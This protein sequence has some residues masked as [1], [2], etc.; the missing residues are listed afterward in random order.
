[1]AY[2]KLKK[3]FIFFRS[4]KFGIAL[5]F[6]I[7]AVSMIGTVIPQGMDEGLYLSNYSPLAAKLILL[8]GFNSIYNSIVFGALFVMLVINLSLC[9]IFRFNRTITKIKTVPKTETLS[10]EETSNIIPN[11]SINC[12]ID[13]SF[14]KYGFNKYFQDDKTDTYFS[15]KNKVGYFGSWFLHF[16]ILIVIVFYTYG[17]I[18]YFSE[19]VYGVPGTVQ[20]IEGTEYMVKISDFNIEYG[21]DGAIQQYTSDIELTDESG[22]SLIDSHVAV[23][24]PMRYKGYSF[25][26]TGYGWTA[27]CN[28]FKSGASLAEEIIYEQTTLNLPNENITIYFNK[29]YPDFAASSGGFSSL[30]DQLTNPVILY[31]VFYRGNVVKM[32]I[33]SVDE[34]IKWNEYEFVFNS[35]IRYTYLEVNKMNG[36]LGALIGA[37]LIVI[38]LILA[39]YYKPSRMMICIKEGKLYVFKDPTIKKVYSKDLG[40]EKDIYA[41]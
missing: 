17:N 11:D 14:R 22:K 12:L 4:M 30:T 39:F 32:D 2:K 5:L 33:S 34:I 38:G 19:G 28:V 35:P 15:V 31:T 29:F 13:E 23:N 20:P 41:K 10:L 36:Q 25:Y 7:M 21:K 40:K 26:Q 1:M 24:E 9:S 37:L 16:G 6:I 8:F 27:K 18:T 3:I